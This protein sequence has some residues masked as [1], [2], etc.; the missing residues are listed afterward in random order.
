[1]SQRG[2]AQGFRAALERDDRIV[3]GAAA[4]IRDE[5]RRAVL[6]RLRIKERGRDRLVHLADVLEAERPERG[7]LAQAATGSYTWRMC[8]KPNG[9]SAAW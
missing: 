7:L 4:E 5:D 1:V 9:P 8:S 6:E 3:G 2:G